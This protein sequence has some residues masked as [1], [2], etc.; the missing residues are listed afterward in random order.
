MS[1]GKKVRPFPSLSAR[2]LIRQRPCR[3]CLAYAAI[4]NNGKLWQPYVVRRIEGHGPDE[5]DEMRGKLKEKIAIE[6]RHFD[7]VK[8][9]LLGVVESD[10]GTAH[11]IRDKAILIAGKTG[12]A[13]V[14][15]MAEGPNRPSSKNVREKDRDHAWFV[16]YA[17]ANNP[18]IVV[19]AL[20]EHGGHGSS[21]AAPLVQKVIAA[22]L[23]SVPNAGR[24]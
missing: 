19:V 10:Q 9:G 14:V 2:A 23:S 5:V 4:A 18:Q 21:V 22:Y 15:Q 7:V 16:G 20:M 8:K 13:Q 6:Q 17:P 24:S 3:W 12:T 1:P 11:A